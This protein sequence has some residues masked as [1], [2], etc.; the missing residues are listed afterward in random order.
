MSIPTRAVAPFILIA[1]LFGVAAF[2]QEKKAERKLSVTLNYTGAGTVDDKHKIIVFLFDNP[3]FMS[4]NGMPFTSA[5]ATSKGETLKFT[6]LAQ[7]KVYVV[8]VFDPT[9][10][11]D[12][13]SGPPP[14]GSSLGMY[15]TEPGKPGG[16][17][18]EDGKTAEVEL[19]F[20]DTAKMQ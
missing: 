13:M 4:G 12:G 3:D 17:K 14:S 5:T 15:S 1:A 20:D 6:D 19:R 16:I 8:A 2:G 18:I 10:G 11:Y 9:G 7:E